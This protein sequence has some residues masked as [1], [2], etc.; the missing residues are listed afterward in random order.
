MTGFGTY[1]TVSPP[2]NTDK[3]LSYA[4]CAAQECALNI[5]EKKDL[6]VTYDNAK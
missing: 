5:T 3:L 6:N 2:E 4:K 1:D